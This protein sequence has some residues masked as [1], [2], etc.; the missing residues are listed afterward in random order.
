MNMES[1]NPHTTTG[2]QARKYA[3]IEKIMQLDEESLPQA[4]A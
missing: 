1:I 4:E 3:L 2:L